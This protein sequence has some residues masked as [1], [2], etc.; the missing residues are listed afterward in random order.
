M[1]NFYTKNDWDTVYSWA[2]DSL[3]DDKETLLEII[4]C[5]DPFNQLFYEKY[6]DCGSG[7]SMS[8]CVWHCGRHG[9]SGAILKRRCASA[10]DLIGRL[11]AE[12]GDDGLELKRLGDD[13]YV[14]D[15]YTEKLVEA[16]YQELCHSSTNNLQTLY[17]SLESE[18]ESE[19]SDSD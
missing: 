17:D 15:F 8:E 11:I 6:L 5:D 7:V 3:S 12:F 1:T 10:F 13:R 9:L 18:M 14:F 4:N 19:S 16:V 2:T